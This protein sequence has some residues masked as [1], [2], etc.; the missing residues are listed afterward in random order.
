MKY[1]KVKMP[2]LCIALYA[3]AGMLVLYT[4]WSASNSRSYISELVAMGQ[5]TFKGNEYDIVNFY[6]SN[7]AQYAL[8]AIILFTLGWITQKISLRKPES[9]YVDNKAASAGKVAC[10]EDAED[11]FEDWFQNNDH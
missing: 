5:L 6:M 9:V 11:D 4:I 2:I 10:N 1:N 8:F 7:S 3:S